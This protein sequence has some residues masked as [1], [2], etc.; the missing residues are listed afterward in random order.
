MMLVLEKPTKNRFVGS[1]A[2]N[3]MVIIAIFCN[4]SAYNNLN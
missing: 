4:I 1:A 2:D 3:W